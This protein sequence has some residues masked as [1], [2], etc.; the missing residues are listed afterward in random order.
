MDERRTR[1]HPPFLTK[2]SPARRSSRLKRST[3]RSP[4]GVQTDSCPPIGPAVGPRTTVEIAREE[5]LPIGLTQE[6]VDEVER[7]G[8]IC[9]DDGGGGV[10]TVSSHWATSGGGEVRWWV[11]VFRGYVWDGQE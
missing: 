6:M 4:S 3:V 9:R 8:E 11:N 2:L 5:D 1:L 10:S 7:D